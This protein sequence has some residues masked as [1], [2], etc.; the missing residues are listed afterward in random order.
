MTAL[1]PTAF[2]V[3]VWGSILGIAAVFVFEAYV[4]AREAGWFAAR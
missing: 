4:I 1:G 3:I 2:A